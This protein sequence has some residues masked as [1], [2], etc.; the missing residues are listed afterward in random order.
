MRANQLYTARFENFDNE[1]AAYDLG[2]VSYGSFFS[3]ST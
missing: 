2:S 3:I 1:G